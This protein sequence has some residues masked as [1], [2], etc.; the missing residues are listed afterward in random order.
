VRNQGGYSII[1]LIIALGLAVAGT[2]LAT[3]CLMVTGGALSR[4]G[5]ESASLIER[6]R[7]GEFVASLLA[8][9]GCGE[10]GEPL[11][12]VKSPSELRFRLRPG[13]DGPES[14]VSLTITGGKLTVKR[15]GG[16]RWT[17]FADCP[18]S[19]FDVREDEV[20]VIPL[21]EGQDTAVATRPVIDRPIPWGAP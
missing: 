3:R 10:P 17:L 12:L 13:I 5:K 6:F 8:W 21:G 11:F 19:G 18:A 15:E 4:T 9:S 20:V 14:T 7:A 16:R 2:A 1:S